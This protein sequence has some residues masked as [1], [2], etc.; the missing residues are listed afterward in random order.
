MLIR[1]IGILL[2]WFKKLPL[3]L[4]LG[5]R[6]G[7]KSY[8]II[9]ILKNSTRQIYS[10]FKLKF[11]NYNHLR[12]IDLLWLPKHIELVMDEFYSIA[13]SRS[14]MSYINVLASYI[15]F[16]LRKTDTQIYITAQQLKSIDVRYRD[17]WDYVVF[18]ERVKNESPNWRKW[19]FGYRIY[20]KRT[21]RSSKHLVL[22]DY[23]K[24]SFH[25]YDTNEIIEPRNKSR[26]A[27][28]FYKSEPKLWLLQGLKFAKLIKSNSNV[29]TKEKIEIALLS[30]NID[31]IWT[32]LCYKLLKK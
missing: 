23:A 29:S 31:S 20:D 32:S 10:N 17:E 30:N 15:A 26:M 22:Y 21:K 14:S 7:G 6:G 12:L 19:D 9:E 11:K 5:P 24:K 2:R 4:I 1:L 18:C 16:Q 25:L 8:F 13:D 27:Y 28:E 3:T